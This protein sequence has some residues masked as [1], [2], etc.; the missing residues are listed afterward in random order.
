LG[1]F[2]ILPFSRFLLR[3]LQ[4][5][6]KNSAKAIPRFRRKNFGKVSQNIPHFRNRVLGSATYQ[7]ITKNH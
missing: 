2:R 5:F 1:D 7:L 6:C 3:I 4:K